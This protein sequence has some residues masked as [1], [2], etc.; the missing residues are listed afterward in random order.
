MADRLKGAFRSALCLGN[1]HS[2]GQSGLM[3]DSVQGVVVAPAGLDC[4]G[5]SLPSGSPTVCPGFPTI[6]LNRQQSIAGVGNGADATDDV[7]F[8][9][10]MPANVLSRNG[11]A[12]LVRVIGSVAA[13]GNTKTI[14]V[15]FGSINFKI[16]NASGNANAALFDYTVRVVRTGSKLQ[17]G[18][19]AGGANGTTVTGFAK[20]R[21]DGAG[22][23]AVL[24]MAQDDTTALVINVTGK[25]GSSAANDV[26]VNEFE[27]L[28][29]AA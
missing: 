14:T 4:E 27:V 15:N 20:A 12:I 23:V 10:T 26:V 3:L 7:L 16:V 11:D 28:M 21:E 6:T 18:L 17:Y 22:N 9:Y 2:A 8:T 1:K 5:D 29:E 19:L 24:S 25:S 13:N